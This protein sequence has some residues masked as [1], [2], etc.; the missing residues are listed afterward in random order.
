MRRVTTSPKRYGVIAVLGAACSFLLAGA[1]LTAQVNPATA[2]AAAQTGARTVQVPVASR[3][4]A[5]TR[6]A[7]AA[8]PAARPA[9]KPPAEKPGIQPV[10]HPSTTPGRRD[11]FSI[12]VNKETTGNVMA[13]VNLP[14]GKS[15]LQVQTLMIQGIVGG[16]SGMIAVVA[17]PQQRVY[18]LRE[19]D[20]LFDGTVEHIAIS[21]VTF[22]EVGKDAFG[23]PLE[24]EVTRRLST[25]SGE[26]P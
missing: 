2:K 16:P 6:R 4:P 15:G 21:G 14:P 12:L 9:A 23:K 11:P 17:N 1:P 5:S 8:A 18:F 20:Q 13:P 19:G 3:P 22:H 24:R 7:P 26:Q 25:S 10:E